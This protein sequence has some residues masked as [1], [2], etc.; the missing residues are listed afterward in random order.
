MEG[1]EQDR[2]DIVP[3]YVLHTFC[4]ICAAAEVCAAADLTGITAD[5]GRLFCRTVV[6]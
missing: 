4:V 2:R 3:S 5:Y 6:R 1:L